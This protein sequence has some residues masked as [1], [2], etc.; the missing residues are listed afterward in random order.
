M[1]STLLISTLIFTSSLFAVTTETTTPPKKKKVA[2]SASAKQATIKDAVSKK[3]AAPTSISSP[4]SNP[5]LN[6]VLTNFTS[7]GFTS[8]KPCKNCD[9]ST[10]FGVNASYL[11][12]LP[13]Y[14]NDKLQI[15]AEGGIASVSAYGNS[16][17]N[18]NLLGVGVFNIDNDFKNSIFVK[19]GLGLYTVQAT[20]TSTETKFGLFVGG[21]KRFAW[22]NNVTFSP[23]LRIVK[24]GDLDIGF[25]A[26]LLNFS[27]YWN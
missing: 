13:G 6:E 26:N 23:E 4:A 17:T 21:G 15:G 24:K 1:K 25:E 3:D 7:G 20:G 19:A 14:L 2:K 9:S 5:F 11:R 8:S 10:E 18:I 22:L 27:I 12:F 16:N